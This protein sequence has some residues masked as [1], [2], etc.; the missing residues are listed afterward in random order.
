MG[1]FMFFRRLFSSL[2]KNELINAS[3]ILFIDQKGQKLEASV[4]SILNQF[5][6][7]RFDLVEVNP[8]HSPPICRLISKSEEFKRQLAIEDANVKQRLRNR[9][10]EIKFGTSMAEHDYGIKL[11][12]T[13]ELLEKAFRVKVT[14][15]PKGVVNRDPLAKEKLWRQIFADLGAGYGKNLIVICPPQ[16]EFRNLTALIALANVKPRSTKSEDNVQN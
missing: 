5:D 7:K 8:T 9:E 14:V 1:C 2:R 3:K 4:K 10:K 6:R 12:R 15:E 11:R 16:V 13:R